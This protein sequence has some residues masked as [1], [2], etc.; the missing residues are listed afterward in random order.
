MCPCPPKTLNPLNQDRWRKRGLK[1]SYTFCETRQ[2]ARRKKQFVATDYLLPKGKATTTVRQK[3]NFHGSAA[4]F[5]PQ[6]GGKSFHR[7]LPFRLPVWGFSA[8][9]SRKPT[10]ASEAVGAIS[11]VKDTCYYLS[12]YLNSLSL[13][14]I[15]S[16]NITGH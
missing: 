4:L 5:S 9:C 15:P 10:C 1:C 3:K 7:H 13:E 8:W 11:S 6:P 12:Q 14:E 16:C 2:R